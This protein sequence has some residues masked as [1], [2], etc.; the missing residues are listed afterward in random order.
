MSAHQLG[1]AAYALRDLRGTV[2]GGLQDSDF[3]APVS[4]DYTERALVKTFPCNRF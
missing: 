4:E 3:L 2:Y 1:G